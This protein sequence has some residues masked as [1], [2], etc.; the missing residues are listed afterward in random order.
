MYIVTHE[1]LIK[2]RFYSEIFEHTW[3]LEKN[4]EKHGKTWIMFDSHHFNLSPSF[5]GVNPTSKN[6]HFKKKARIQATLVL[7]VL[8]SPWTGYKVSPLFQFGKLPFEPSWYFCINWLDW[9]LIKIQ[10]IYHRAY[11]LIST[12]DPLLVV[13][14]DVVI[15]TQG[16]I[17]LITK[18]CQLSQLQN[19]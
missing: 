4:M 17:I 18:L 1:S 10:D 11:K 12:T 6:L 5:Q 9:S 19:G 3:M 16:R 14:N 15:R 13:C 2:C 8:F 7:L